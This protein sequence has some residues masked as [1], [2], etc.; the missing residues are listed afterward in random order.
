[1]MH[2]GHGHFCQNLDDRPDN[3]VWSTEMVLAD[4]AEALGFEFA[5]SVMPAL[6]KTVAHRI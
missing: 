1:M 3:D 5:R 2:I 4:R 6:S